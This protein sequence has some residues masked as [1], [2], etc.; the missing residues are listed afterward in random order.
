MRL[1]C[2]WL[3]CCAQ[4]ATEGHAFHASKMNLNP[5]SAACLHVEVEELDRVRPHELRVG[6]RPA[7]LQAQRRGFKALSSSD[8]R[9]KKVRAYD[10]KKYAPYAKE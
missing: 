10:K 5:L 2:A 3:P 6:R 7:V 4:L 9:Q 1:V 8:M